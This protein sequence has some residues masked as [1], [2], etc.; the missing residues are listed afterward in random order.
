MYGH[1]KSD[2]VW[3][4]LVGGTVATLVSLLFT[5]KKGKQIQN[6]VSDLYE[7]VEETIKATFQDAK[8]KVEEG[9]EHVS[10]KVAGKKHDDDDHHHKHSK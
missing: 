10:K 9:V 5:T 7:D 4:A 2:F 8:D 3:G 1:N 6:K